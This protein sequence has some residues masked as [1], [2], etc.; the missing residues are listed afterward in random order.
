MSWTGILAR[1]LAALV[2]LALPPVEYR[3]EPVKLEGE[4]FHE[5]A[6]MAPLTGA[7]PA[8]K[9]QPLRYR[10]LVEDGLDSYADGFAYTV[11]RAL[12]AEDGWGQAGRGFELVEGEDVDFTVILAMPATT[13]LLCAPLNT[14]RIFSCGRDYKAVVNLRRWQLGALA[15]GPGLESYRDYVITHEVGHLLGLPHRPC[16]G[17]GRTSPVMAQQ[18]KTLGGCERAS[19]PSASEIAYLRRRWINLGFDLD[20]RASGAG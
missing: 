4:A 11:H 5:V 20:R 9:E 13:D 16:K 8:T 2:E 14:G 15:W 18:S 3:D 17:R 10:I 12:S 6:A 7:Y 19:K 1:A